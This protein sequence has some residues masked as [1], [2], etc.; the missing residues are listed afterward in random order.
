MGKNEV[1][2]VFLGVIGLLLGG[3]P[4]KK[5]DVLKFFLGVTAAFYFIPLFR[6]GMHCK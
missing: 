4:V 5:M 6:T 2:E 1:H 3:G